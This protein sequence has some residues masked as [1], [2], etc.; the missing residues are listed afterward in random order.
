[1]VNP[2]N[3][4]ADFDKGRKRPKDRSEKYRDRTI[5][6]YSLSELIIGQM[7]NVSSGEPSGD[8]EKRSYIYVGS[9][10][11]LLRE[12]L[13]SF[14]TKAFASWD[15]LIRPVSIHGDGN[16]PRFV[17]IDD[18]CNQT[19]SSLAQPPIQSSGE[20]HYDLL[21]TN[22]ELNPVKSGHD[23]DILGQGTILPAASGTHISATVEELND[24]D[25]YESDYRFFALKGPL[26]MTGPGYDINGKPVPNASDNEEDAASGIFTN[27]CLTDE[28]LDGYMKKSH[29]WPV[30]PI[31]LRLDRKRGVWV[32]PPSYKFVL[33]KLKED[34]EPYSTADAY[35]L[36]GAP[37]Y[38]DSGVVIPFD[39]N[40][41][42][43]VRDYLGNTVLSG[44]NLLLYY[45][46]DS[47]EFIPI[48]YSSTQTTVDPEER[49]E[50]IEIDN[51]CTGYCVWEW[52]EFSGGASGT[53]DLITDYCEYVG[54]PET[55]TTFDVNSTTT[56]TTTQFPDIE[57]P[58][59]GSGDTTTTT[60]IEP[61]GS[62][63]CI[64]P[65]RCGI[66]DGEVVRTSCISSEFEV[67]TGWSCPPDTDP[68][69]SGECTTSS[70]TM[71][72][73]CSGC[74]WRHWARANG[75]TDNDGNGT[76]LLLYDNCDHSLNCT[77]YIPT[78][79]TEIYCEE[80]TF[81]CIHFDTT[82]TAPVPCTGACY[83]VSVD[84][85]WIWDCGTC[86]DYVD[87][88]LCIAPSEPPQSNYCASTATYCFTPDEPPSSTT[89]DPCVEN[90]PCE[91][92][93]SC[94]FVVTSGNA[95]M[96]ECDPCDEEC[97]CAWP[98]FPPW[99]SAEV[100]YSKCGSTETT[101]TTTSTTSSSSTTT[102]PTLGVCCGCPSDWCTDDMSE[103]ECTACGG[104]Q[105]IEGGD[106][107]SDCFDLGSC[108]S[109]DGS[110][111]ETYIFACPDDWTLDGVCEP[112]TCP[113]APTTTT[114]TTTAAP[115]GACCYGV[116]ES[117]CAN[118]T[119]EECN[120]DLAGVWQG[121]G[122]ACDDPG[123]CPIDCTGGD[124]CGYCSYDA[125]G[126][127]IDGGYG[128]E[129]PCGCP[130][131]IGPGEDGRD[132]CCFSI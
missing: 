19:S 32:S 112:N 100:Y 36:S 128:C 71:D 120:N 54:P 23:I 61:S 18:F 65:Q 42:L 88:C 127:L 53:W 70:T 126:D 110:C 89:L 29:T 4:P 49:D 98:E 37:I 2:N 6:P 125:N 94:R 60:T 28:F 106:C 35:Q 86:N 31:D 9:A 24:L 10:P 12:E 5:N 105:W 75:C 21:I 72:P 91:L 117:L 103:S 114:T 79:I 57:Y 80:A 11:N 95:W 107:P 130:A 46:T 90:D 124:D 118:V 55:T 97:P 34:L 14:D 96:K 87:N 74:T 13:N 76:L 102:P 131:H 108:C 129:G 59:C 27:Q 73:E 39:E 101:T 45:D 69:N 38:N 17:S 123:M 56:T 52:Q 25:P 8:Y 63:Q 3:G 62:C 83:W 81:P 109:G 7:Y 132:I 99:G 1:M 115:D 85:Q 116:T 48:D 104:S 47:C 22:D 58:S 43:T 16:L 113:G 64:P 26:I 122:T 111:T 68:C 50:D 84:G 51:V 92:E 93:L 66:E 20:T 44:E 119:E 67:V 40:N 82:T 30:A 15:S 41:T 77:C 33:A 78:P 121:A